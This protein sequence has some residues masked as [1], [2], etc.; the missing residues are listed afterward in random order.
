M[1]EQPEARFPDAGSF[2][3]ALPPTFA[4][5]VRTDTRP[6]EGH[7][8]LR[9]WLVV[10]ALVAAAAVVAIAIGIWI[11]RL[12][13]GGPLGV[14]PRQPE[15]AEPTSSAGTVNPQVVT[16]L[17]LVTAIA[18]DPFGDGGENDAGVPLAIDGDAGTAWR[19]ENYFDPT[20]NNKP[21]VGLLFDLG[22]TR[23]VTGFRLRVPHPGYTF[24]LAVGDDPEQLASS[25]AGRY[26]AEVAMRRSI[27]PTEGRYVLLWVTSVIDVGDGNRAEVAEFQVIG[28]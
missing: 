28:R 21:G 25:V 4:H 6:H 9:G 17:P 26:S 12:E 14:R 16:V 2:A 7:G 23:T 10:P 11:G 24:G 20:M 27:D 13:L 18:Y 8:I 22:T 19:S 15:E 3:D 5:E 1:A